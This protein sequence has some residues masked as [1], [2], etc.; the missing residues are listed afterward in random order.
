MKSKVESSR[1]R[2][3]ITV[4]VGAVA[5]LASLPALAANGVIATVS[6]SDI[7]DPHLTQGSAGGA[8]LANAF[9]TL[10]NPNQR[11]SDGRGRVVPGIATAWKYSDDGKDIDFT[12]RQDV[13]F[14]NGEKMTAED[15]AYS[16]NRIVDPKTKMPYR[17]SYFANLKGAEVISPTVVR[18]HYSTPW[19]GSLEAL[20]AR[21]HI[22]PK[23][24]MEKLGSEEFSKKPIGTGPFA[25]ASYKA[26]DRLEFK[27]FDKY[28]GGKPYFDNL[29]WRAIPDVNT[30]V[31]M[32]CSG[33][34]DAITDIEPPML[35]AI[36]SCGQNAAIL[37]GIHQR[38]LIMNTLQEG[39]PFKDQ[40]VRMAMNIAIDRKEVFD[41]I[42]G[43]E[44]AW[45]NGALSPYHIGG[46]A[47]ERYPYD[48]EKA[49][50]LLA[51]AGHP[52]GF[53]TE[54]VYTPG[55]YFD[56]SQLL[57]TLVSYWKKIGVT[58]NTRPVEY[59][60]W[61]KFAGSKAYKGMLSYSKGAGTIADPTSAFD[62]HVM[63]GALYSAFC[64]PDLD[65]LVKSATGVIDENKLNEI[66]SK[67]QKIS[68]EDAPAVFLYDLPTIFGWKKTLSWNSEYG[69]TEQGASWADLR[70]K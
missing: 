25:V 2:S 63:C 48:P 23:D 16:I 17:T 59:N 21:G 44:V 49:K 56:D 45:V 40:R 68:H 70:G 1:W 60:E 61:L 7:L 62:R 39:S 38:F 64:D 28:W 69:A 33:E 31:A 66:F 37:R 22:I 18:L 30:R 20:A 65:A 42:F 47:A 4:M 14:H 8:Y 35:K 27:G 43:T 12:I 54:I 19:P 13:Y 9:D 46:Q 3:T 52:N 6:L 57:P 29:S 51:E 36:K 58:V 11:P 5:L 32:L 24:Y 34:A 26:G 55:R 53:T 10:V 50:K 41:S 67:A 15:V